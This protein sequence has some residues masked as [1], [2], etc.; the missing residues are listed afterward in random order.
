MESEIYKLLLAISGT[1]I[2]FLLGI[3]G[4]FL[5]KHIKVIELLVTAVNSLNVTVKLLKNDQD[6]AS[7]NCSLTHK[8]ITTRLN[9]HS[10]KLQEHG[11]AITELK[12]RAE[13]E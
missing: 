7:T 3:I 1:L 11:I 5:Q 8:V 9:A 4:F 10:A 2:V 13:H 6:N 12:T